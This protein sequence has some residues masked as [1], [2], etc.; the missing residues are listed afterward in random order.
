MKRSHLKHKP[1]ATKNSTLTRS[2]PYRFLFGFYLG[3]TIPNPFQNGRS[4]IGISEKLG[5]LGKP[6]KRHFYWNGFSDNTVNLFFPD[7]K[8][9][10]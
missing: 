9:D 8:S 1:D 5:F 7:W 4:Y 10:F 2:Q 6:D 3:Y